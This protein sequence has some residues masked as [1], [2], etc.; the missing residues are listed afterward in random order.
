LTNI[1]LLLRRA[2][3][4]VCSDCR[5]TGIAYYKNES[6]NKKKLWRHK[7]FNKRNLVI[8]MAILVLGVVLLSAIKINYRCE[9]DASGNVQTNGQEPI[10]G[11][12]MEFMTSWDGSP[13]CAYSTYTN[14]D[15]NYDAFFGLPDGSPSFY[16]KCTTFTANGSI[17]ETSISTNY[18]VPPIP[19]QTFTYSGIDFVITP[20][21]GHKD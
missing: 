17:D 7:M 1:L 4:V 19:G 2:S 14:Q 13:Y 3:A 21:A 16:V 8:V 18:I 11:A 10:D 5:L 15:G 20:T 9:I 6:L 12:L